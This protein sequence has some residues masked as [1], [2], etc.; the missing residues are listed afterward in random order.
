MLNRIRSSQTVVLQASTWIAANPAAARVALAILAF[1]VATGSML[2]TGQPVF[3][4]LCS[5]SGGGC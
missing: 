2:L 4:D 3:A 1:A 5:T